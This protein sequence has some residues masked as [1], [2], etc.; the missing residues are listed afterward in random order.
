[1]FIKYYNNDTRL[2]IFALLNVDKVLEFRV[3]LI[4]DNK[5]SVNKLA[6]LVAI[7][8]NNNANRIDFINSRI[9]LEDFNTVS[10]AIEMLNNLCVAI[11][12][13]SKF[14]VAIKD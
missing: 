10:E 8:D 2:P 7:L 12:N 11:E 13:G 5:S 1:M 3:E 6:K 4:L 14:F 9:T